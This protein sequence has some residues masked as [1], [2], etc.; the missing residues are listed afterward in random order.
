MTDA[1]SL[2][3]AAPVGGARPRRVS[4][5]ARQ[6]DRRVPPRAQLEP[7]VRRSAR[8]CAAG[9]RGRGRAASAREVGDDAPADCDAARDGRLR[10]GPR[11][12]ARRGVPGSGLRADAAR[13]A[14][15]RPG[16][17]PFDGPL[18]PGD[19]VGVTFVTGDLAARRHRNGH[20]HRRRSR[21]RVR[22]PDVQP[23]ADRVPDDARVRLHR[24]AEPVLVD[25]SCRRRASRSAR[26]CRIARRRLPDVSVRGPRCIPVTL[27][28]E[29]ERGRSAR[30]TS[31]SCAISSSRR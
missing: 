17:M 30:S 11:R 6:P 8:R 4:A 19:A 14:G 21:L 26:F 24:A 23:R 22:S 27:T 25:R 15:A 7:A 16:D 12:D 5:H 13:A 9:R 18:K 2:D 29:A 1:T 31:A 28:L 20:A 10:A 3:D